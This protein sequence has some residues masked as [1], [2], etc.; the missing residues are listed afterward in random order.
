MPLCRRYCGEWHRSPS[1]AECFSLVFLPSLS[2]VPVPTRRPRPAVEQVWSSRADGASSPGRASN[3]T[4]TDR[5]RG[6]RGWGHAPNTSADAVW[7]NSGRTCSCRNGSPGQ[8]VWDWSP[9]VRSP[10]ERVRRRTE[11][12]LRLR[13]IDTGPYRL[14]DCPAGSPLLGCLVGV[15]QV[16][17]A[18]SSRCLSGRAVVAKTLFPGWP[19]PLTRTRPRPAS[20]RASPHQRMPS[21]GRGSCS[22]LFILA[23]IAARRPGHLSHVSARVQHKYPVPPAG[24]ELSRVNMALGAALFGTRP[25]GTTRPGFARPEGKETCQRAD[26]LASFGGVQAP[27]NS[28]LLLCK[29][30]TEYGVGPLAT[31]RMTCSPPA[32]HGQNPPKLPAHLACS[33]FGRCRGCGLQLLGF[34]TRS[35]TR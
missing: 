6:R 21:L 25:R 1:L 32:L 19:D 4:A 22:T 3:A 35:Q 13:D 14:V 17:P 12:T 20:H 24:Q 8:G 16:K 15:P 5:E 18:A 33:S 9:A 31:P 23:R 34:P 26:L 11:G 7:S 29:Y 30:S 2:C 28:Y 10:Q 27:W